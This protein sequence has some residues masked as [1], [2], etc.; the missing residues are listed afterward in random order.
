MDKQLA[1]FL[2]KE[3]PRPGVVSGLI[4]RDPQSATRATIVEGGHIL[5]ASATPS[6]PPTRYAIQPAAKTFT[7]SKDTYVYVDGVTGAIAYAEVA[8]DAAKPALSALA[9]NS[10]FIAKVVTDGSR[11]V[12]GGVTD[13]RELAPAFIE[14]FVRH[15][16]FVTA[17]QGATGQ[18]IA[19]CRGRLLYLKSVVALA[20]GG[21]DTGTVTAAIG[22][23]NKFAA[24]TDGVLTLAISAAVAE[25]DESTPSA[26]N[27]FNAGD[28]VRL[29]AAKTTTG[30]EAQVEV[31]WERI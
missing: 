7:A 3:P 21:T 28:V 18:W 14:S 4:V 13:L 9:A 16:S 20:L 22:R 12:D 1:G 31:L 25:I 30:G 15:V 26:A 23:N 5:I 10:Q 24:V 19:P 6:N 27:E 8:N 11:I 29:T 2:L 17:G